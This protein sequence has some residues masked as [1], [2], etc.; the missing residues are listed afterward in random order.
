[1][2]SA[3]GVVSTV[4]AAGLN[5]TL[6]PATKLAKATWGPYMIACQDANGQPAPVQRVQWTF[7]LGNA[8]NG[9]RTL[10]AMAI[11]AD[12]KSGSVAAS[13]DKKTHAAAFDTDSN[14]AV[15]VQGSKLRAPLFYLIL[16]GVALPLAG[17]T[18]WQS[19]RARR[20]S[21]SLKSVSQSEH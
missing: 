10:S 8:A 3:D 1:V 6:T 19:W 11:G 9:Y 21:A 18:V 2:K 17:M 15:G 4:V 5:C 13:Y 12:G 7:N 20:S 16:A 14:G